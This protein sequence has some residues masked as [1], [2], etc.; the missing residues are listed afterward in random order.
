MLI[1]ITPDLRD[2]VRSFFIEQW[3]TDQMIVSSGTYDC[4]Q[5]DGF[6]WM[7]DDRIIGLITYVRRDT[8]VEII[9]LDSLVERRGIGSS[10]L[11]AIETYSRESKLHRVVVLTTNDNLAAL[12]YYQRRGYRMTAIICNAVTEARRLKPSIPVVGYDGIPLYDE[13]FLTKSMNGERKE[14]IT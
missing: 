7:E 9:S 12:G 8:E 2:D 1:S 4:A 14:G 11:E 10:L 5:L 3:G 13:V 6:V